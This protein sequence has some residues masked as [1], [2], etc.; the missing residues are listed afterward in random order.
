VV[1]TPLLLVGCATTLT[2]FVPLGIG[3]L[4]VKLVEFEIVAGMA[5][6]VA[7]LIAALVCPATVVLVELL[8]IAINWFKLLN[9]PAVVVLAVI[10]AN[11]L[12]AGS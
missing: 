3:T 6:T 7:L 4:A 2:T 10:S 12:P 8:V 1:R 11:R 9:W 5:S